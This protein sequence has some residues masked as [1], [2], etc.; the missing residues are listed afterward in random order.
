M[1]SAPHAVRVTALL[2]LLLLTAAAPTIAQQPSAPT[3]TRFLVTV[4]R[5]KPEMVDQWMSIQRDEVIPAQKK[6]GV[7]GRTT[8]TTAVG[9]SFEYTIITPFPS[10]GAMD[11]DV[12]LVRALGRE[13]AARVNA[14]LRPC[15]LTQQM[16]MTNRQE[17][18]QVDPGGAPIWR[19]TVRRALP[20]K[21]QEYLAHMA[22]SVVPAMQKAKAEGKI[23]GFGVAT[24]GV[25]APAG[26]LTTIT[27]YAKF[28]D[29]EAGDPLVLTLGREG[30]SAV[31]AKSS[32]MA[33]TVMTIV[34]RRLAD[35][36]F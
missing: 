34:R 26:E 20:G 21:M 19:T 18:L 17:A 30:A 24:R 12:P 32:A 22:S 9:N 13:G 14:K 4:V 10:F 5:L 33:P 11:G 29:M 8:L 25:G 36:S 31:N 27:Y 3:T 7:T 15:I 28:G 16:F 1:R 23:A 2:P 35:L 6:A